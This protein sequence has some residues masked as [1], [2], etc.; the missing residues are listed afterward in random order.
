MTISKYLPSHIYF[1]SSD[2]TTR[3][4]TYTFETVSEN[5]A[6]INQ[7]VTSVQGESEAG[8]DDGWV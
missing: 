2:L 4:V 1:L 7:S 3:H 6:K 8:S 5:N